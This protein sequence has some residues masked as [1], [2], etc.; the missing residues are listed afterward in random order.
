MT[1][2]T[3]LI[4]VFVAAMALGPLMWFRSTPAQRREI[5]ARKHAAELGLRVHLTT[6]ANLNLPGLEPN[7]TV[8]AYCLV[9]KPADKA[10][11]KAPLEARPWRLIKERIDHEAHFEGYWNWQKHRQAEPKW[12][13]VLKEVLKQLPKDVQAIDYDRGT[14]C[15]YWRERGG[16][17]D[18]QRLLDVMH[19]LLEQVA[20]RSV[21]QGEV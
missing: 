21:P 5:E 7:D 9:P 2:V 12:H 13:P 10:E 4:I 11:G 15:I 16:R 19:Y 1:W 6:A 3:A 14:L 17:D 20:A 8:A 18:V